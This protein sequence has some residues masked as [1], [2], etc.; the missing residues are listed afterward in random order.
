LK[1]EAAARQPPAVAELPP[2][3]PAANDEK[4]IGFDVN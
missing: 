4:E 3:E 1:A 2:I